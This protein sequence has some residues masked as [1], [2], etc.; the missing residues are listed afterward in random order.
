M[1]TKRLTMVDI[2]ELAGVSVSTVSRALSDNPSVAEETRR[3]V[4]DIA[5]RH[6]YVLDERARNFRLRKT[7]T[8]ATVFPFTGV[9]KRTLSDP[10]YMELIGAIADELDG[11]G[12]DLTI[13]RAPAD[14]TGWYHKFIQNRRVDGLIVVDR[15][16]SDPGL[17]R[18]HELDTKFVVWGP[19][20]TGQRY[21]SVGGDSCAGA[22]M[23]VHHLASRGRKRF[24]FIGGC[25]DMVET[26]ERYRGYKQG[27]CDV[28]LPFDEN[29]AV[30]TDFSQQESSHA[31]GDLLGRMPD[32]DGLFVCSDFMAIAAMEVLRVEGRDVPRDVSVVGY[33]DIQLSAYC[34]PRLTTIRQQIDVGG[35]LLARNILDLLRGKAASSVMLPIDL[36]V[37]DSS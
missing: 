11:Q 17:E 8:I 4:R 15:L 20:I 34:S 35:R 2:G 14:D 5:R 33:D 30:F 6:N 32:L 13:A 21:I 29:M 28:G 1:S 31:V 22:V 24:G 23:A 16:L 12:Y 10:F 18:L 9:S 36:A 27:M 7:Q 3:R 19:A 26:A 37:R 25:R